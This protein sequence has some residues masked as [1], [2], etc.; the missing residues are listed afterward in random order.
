MF[1]IK[2]RIV[3]KGL[4]LLSVPLRFEVIAAATILFLQH[5]YSEAVKAEALRTEVLYHIKEVWKWNIS[6]TANSLGA[7][8][9]RQPV[10]DEKNERMY[11]SNY[12]ILEKLLSDNPQQLEKLQE[13]QN[14]HETILAL[15]KQLKE[16]LSAEHSE[17]E[18]VLDL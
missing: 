11:S 1:G 16:S 4:I 2:P 13:V 15:S 14:G 17:I 10:G 3:H 18:Q 7:R 6:V 5:S 8:L 12:R 9:M